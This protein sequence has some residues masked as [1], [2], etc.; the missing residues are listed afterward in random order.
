MK[1]WNIKTG[2]MVNQY[3]EFWYSITGLAVLPSGLLVTG[4]LDY[5]IRI[6][7]M[8]S[9]QLSYVS[10]VDYIEGILFNPVVSP[11]G[12][13]VA[14]M[15]THLKFYN[16]VTYSPLYSAT[17]ATSFS[18]MD[19]VLPSGNVLIGGTSLTIYNTTASIVYTNVNSFTITIIKALTD[20]V[21]VALGCSSGSIVLFNSNTNTFGTTFAAHSALVSMMAVTPDNVFILSGSSDNQ[22][23]LW[24]WGTMSLTQM[25][26][27]SGVTGRVLS[28]AFINTANTSN[29]SLF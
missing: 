1:V 13:I 22:V 15:G 6:W 2:S 21:S 5:Y 3:L 25:H 28:A 12:A 19:L 14:L 20:N 11:N 23:I 27:Y 26:V 24:M 17:I 7:D 10:E 18:C 29:D 16:A 4:S 9:N 8:Q